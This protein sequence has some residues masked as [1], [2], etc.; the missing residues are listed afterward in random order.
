MISRETCRVGQDDRHALTGGTKPAKWGREALNKRGDVAPLPLPP[1][2]LTAWGAKRTAA[3]EEGPL[4]LLGAEA[5]GAEATGEQKAIEA[6]GPKAGGGGAGGGYTALFTEAAAA[7][8]EGALAIQGGQGF[9][10]GQLALTV[11]ARALADSQDKPERDRTG[12]LALEHRTGASQRA[13]LLARSAALGAAAKA[14]K[15]RELALAS[16]KRHKEVGS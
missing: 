6:P 8:S 1:P 9:E 5:T 16:L 12:A 2:G 13:V 14:A 4:R 3:A 11:A 7:A 10:G 15:S